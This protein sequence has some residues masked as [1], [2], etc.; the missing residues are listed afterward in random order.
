ME[1]VR[2]EECRGLDKGPTKGRWR[3]SIT[4]A[5]CNLLPGNPTHTS[6]HMSHHIFT[7]PFPTRPG[8]EF[9]QR[10]PPLHGFL[11]QQLQEAT[12]SLHAGGRDG[13][14]GSATV[15]PGLYPVLILL[16]RLQPGGGPAA[17]GGSDGNTLT[18]APDAS[19]T[20][21]LIPGSTTTLATMEQQLPPLS[22]AAFVPLVRYCAASAPLMA[23]RQLAA[24]ALV[25]LLAAAPPPLL[26]LV[27]GGGG[28]HSQGESASSALLRSLLEEL[29][30]SPA[31][32]GAKKEGGL[33]AAAPIRLGRNARQGKLFQVEALL[34]QLARSS[35]GV[36][37]GGAEAA[38]ALKLC[39]L[40][41]PMAAATAC[42]SGGA[43]AAAFLRA[44]SAALS[45]TTT[46][47]LVSAG[48]SASSSVSGLAITL[49][50]VCEATI[51]SEQQRNEGSSIGE[52]VSLMAIRTDWSDP[53]RCVMLKEAAKLWTGKAL[54]CTCLASLPPSCGLTATAPL[55]KD[56]VDTV[57]A[58]MAVAAEIERRLVA[59]LASPSYDVR[60]AAVKSLDTLMDALQAE[61]AV[62]VMA[63]TLITAGPH[64]GGSAGTAGS[65]A[66]VAELSSRSQNT[67]SRPSG[68]AEAAMLLPSSSAASQG[69]PAAAEM[70][71]S[72]GGRSASILASALVRSGAAAGLC[73]RLQE[74]L[75]AHLIGGGSSGVGEPTLKVQGR[76]L[77]AMAHL[78][79]I[80]DALPPVHGD[81][82]GGG[83]GEGEEAALMGR[84]AAA[85][86]LLDAARGVEPR[87]AA[88]RC[89]GRALGRAR[90]LQQQ[91]QEG[92]LQLSVAEGKFLASVSEFAMADQPEVSRGAAV[93]ALASSGVLLAPPLPPPPLLMQAVGPTAA[94]APA[95]GEARR[96]R[97][98]SLRAWLVV[99]KCVCGGWLNTP[100]PTGSTLLGCPR[101]ILCRCSVSHSQHRE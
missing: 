7:Y 56:E 32:V 23:V 59:C 96:F 57:A 92:R 36:G 82:G 71:A 98:S 24:K 11:L 2:E 65:W 9:F 4:Q 13:A 64:L 78:Q 81:G 76:C 17:G 75:W 3:W 95:L 29:S 12:A 67:P 100:A 48:A 55:A 68:L 79:A 42:S 34:L 45:L 15:H 22:P 97:G 50:R 52:P 51:S 101:T 80:A 72:D 14:G 84:L 58:A 54:L 18:P 46:A 69:I 89:L 86:H 83:D 41:L 19:S 37:G 61:V 94:Y 6:S 74:V 39:A 16:S 77:R 62:A 91:S 88:L 63:V 33:S 70:L 90:R 28:G 30:P 35:R 44:S 27:P 31:A 38:A 40:H 25:P 93:G 5:G 8:G 26:P 85:Q 73:E 21:A 1:G 53:M 99:L 43:V 66:A 49:S 60:A 87:A 47:P 10:F 20:S